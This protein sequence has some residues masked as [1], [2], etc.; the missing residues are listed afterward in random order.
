MEFSLFGAPHKV[1]VANM[2]Q[3]KQLSASAGNEVDESAESEIQG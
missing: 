2:L 3:E 1:V